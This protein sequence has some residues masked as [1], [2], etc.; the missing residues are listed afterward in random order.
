MVYVD[1]YR[2]PFRGMVMSH[3]VADTE[4]ELDA[5]ASRL[6]LKSRWKQRGGRRVHY[7]VS[8]G[9]RYKA[10]MLGAREVTCHDLARMTVGK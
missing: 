3:L 5:F 4:A 8:E 9:V 10:V 2:A 1:D 7:D 6:G